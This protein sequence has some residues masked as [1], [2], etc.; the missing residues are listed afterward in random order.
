MTFE[1]RIEIILNS[2]HQHQSVAKSVENQQ[3][4][5]WQKHSP[6]WK[7]SVKDAVIIEQEKK[8]DALV[9]RETDCGHFP[10]TPLCQ[11][12]TPPLSHHS[13]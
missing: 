3:H 5:D 11:N 10:L 8:Y 13:Y 9:L 6:W 2:H 7:N 12:K 1:S 4:L